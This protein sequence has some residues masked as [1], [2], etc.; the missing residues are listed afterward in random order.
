MGHYPNTDSVGISVVQTHLIVKL[1]FE[2]RRE[3]T[4][5]F[6]ISVSMGIDENDRQLLGF[7]EL[8]GP[9]LYDTIGKLYGKW[10][11]KVCNEEL[12]R[13]LWQKYLLYVTRATQTWFSR[14]ESP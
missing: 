2:Y 14:Q 4:A 3:T 9:D 7:M 12:N 10:F 8:N 11:I 1:I 5:E 13:F 6:T